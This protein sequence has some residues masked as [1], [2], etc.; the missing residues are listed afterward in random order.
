MKRHPNK[1]VIKQ[2]TRVNCRPSTSV[3]ALRWAFAVKEEAIM[4]ALK[5]R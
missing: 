3:E 1:K 2:W 5:F 4:M